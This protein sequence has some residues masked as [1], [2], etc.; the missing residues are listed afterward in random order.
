M[1]QHVPSRSQMESAASSS[2]SVQERVRSACAGP[3]PAARACPFGSVPST[4]HV[5]RH[6]RELRQ[7]MA[8]LERQESRAWVVRASP[9]FFL[10]ARGGKG[11]CR[12]AKHDVC[13]DRHGVEHAWRPNRTAQTVGEVSFRWVA[14][15]ACPLP[16]V[17][18]ERRGRAAARSQPA[19]MQHLRSAWS[20][21]AGPPAGRKLMH[22][23]P[24]RKSG[25]VERAH[26]DERIV[27]RNSYQRPTCARRWRHRAA[28]RTRAGST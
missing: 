12:V 24:L 3:T 27:S 11:E 17:A 28:R 7:V 19:S 5:A 25:K 21:T 10:R 4:L 14:P 26:A 22:A 20:H 18:A 13:G 8:W 6:G 15:C 1:S 23:F 2:F 16:V 9:I